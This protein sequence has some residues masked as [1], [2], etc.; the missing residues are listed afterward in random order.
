MRLSPTFTLGLVLATSA[1]LPAAA[2]ERSFNF[3]LRGGVSAAPDYP[4]SDAYGAAPDLG[5][6]FGALKWGPINAGNGIYEIPDNGFAFKGAFRYI[7]AREASENPELQG[8]NDIDDTIELGFGVAYREANWQ[9]F[10]EVRKGFGG[11]EGISGTIGAD[12]IF[13]PNSRLTVTAGPRFNLGNDTYAAT[14]FGV[15]GVEALASP[16]FGAFDA[17]GGLLGAGVEVEATYRI[18]DAWAI[19]GAVEYEHL[20]NDAAA[21]PITQFGSEDQWTVRLG[22][23]RAFTLRF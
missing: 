4:G 13:R 9:A 14:Y 19:E 1:A 22:L 5:F 2:Q 8:L 11:S 3:S 15:S 18:G 23:S 12:V 21:S 7:G 10:G 16:N 20:L 17:K 6:T